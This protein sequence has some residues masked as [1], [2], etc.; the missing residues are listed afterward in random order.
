[1]RRILAGIETEYGLLVEGR[2]AE[3][4]VDDAMALV[5][6]YPG[7]CHVGWDYQYESP[8]ADLRGF[9]LARLAQ[10]PDDAKFDAGRSFGEAHEVRS[11]RVLPNG[12]RFYND[13]GHPE[14]AT[15][16]CWSIF[17]LANHDCAGQKVVMRAAKALEKQKHLPVKI[18]KNNTDFHGASYGTHES[19]LVPRGIGFERL[20][21]GA[22][23]MM[24]VRQILVGAGKV[25]SEK[26]RSAGFQLSQRADFLSETANAETLYRRPI[27]NTRDE[28]HADGQQSIRLHVIC[29]DA[30]M[31]PEATARKVGLMK[32]ALALC[33][34]DL[35]PVWS[36]KDPVRAFQ[37]ISRDESYQFRVELEHRSWTTGHEVLESYFSA[38][39]QCLDLDDEMC[40]VIETSRALLSDLTNQFDR[41]RRHVDWAAKR[42]I[43]SQFIEEEGTDWN[44]PHLRSFDLEY[45]NADPE[46]SLHAALIDMEEVEPDPPTPD[47]LACLEGVNERT[48]AFARGLAISKFNKHLLG[49]C[50]R[51]LTFDVEGKPIEVDLSP[52]AEYPP[53]L[54]EANDVG[55][56]ISMLRGVQ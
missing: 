52:N 35:A 48:R 41:F 44:D 15:P 6:G 5:R 2:G 27:F 19:Y 51:T 47:L 11:D 18:Y 13:H 20:Y 49:V 40:W 21:K 1:M 12:A 30:N 16:E 3:E 25:G 50:W 37:E 32:I 26:G 39:E 8:R 56:F 9:K 31:I 17:E 29:G 23:P 10:D 14:Y 45:H 22:L 34:A 53:H 7:E 46:E 43:L 33:E 54:G 36:F 28:P 55:T 24:V 38:A 4:Q 42:A